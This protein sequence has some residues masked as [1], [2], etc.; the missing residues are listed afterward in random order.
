MQPI[1]SNTWQLLEYTENTLVLSDLA[2]MADEIN[3]DLTF[4]VQFIKKG[5]IKTPL[6]IQNSLET[7]NYLSLLEEKINSVFWRIVGLWVQR[8]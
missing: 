3:Q 5:I 7:Q 6:F 4:M 1:R 2:K 8:F